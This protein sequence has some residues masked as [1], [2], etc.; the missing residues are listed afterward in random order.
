MV[1]TGITLVLIVTFFCTL[2]E[3]EDDLA[4]H[5]VIERSQLTLAP[6]GVKTI[7]IK[8]AF[9]SIRT[10]G[11]TGSRVEAFAVIQHHQQDQVVPVIQNHRDQDRLILEVVY[12]EQPQDSSGAPVPGKDKRR[13]DLSAFIP[14]TLNLNIETVDD[15]AES[16]GHKAFLKIKTHAGDI[17]LKSKGWVN[18]AS[19]RGGITAIHQ[20]DHWAKSSTYTTQTGSITIVI[21]ETANIE[22]LIDT[23]GKIT[24]DFSLNIKPHPGSTRKTATAVVGKKNRTL[25]I[26]TAIG[27]VELIRKINMIKSE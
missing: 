18:A 9:G 13:V 6:T 2:V 7:E 21:A 1:K 20:N 24:T 3:A 4:Q 11:S 27:D 26:D 14:D 17:N 23:S 22:I 10:R 25:S 12:P 5:W 8:N 19:E 15:L 16:K